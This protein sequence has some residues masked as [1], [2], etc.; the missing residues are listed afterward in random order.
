LAKRPQRGTARPASSDA[1]TP[2]S[3]RVKTPI[4]APVRA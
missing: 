2:C 4:A 3:A 1:A